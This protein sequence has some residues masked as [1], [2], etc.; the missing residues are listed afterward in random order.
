[1]ET[2]WLDR[3]LVGVDFPVRQ[4][5]VSA[6]LRFIRTGSIATHHIYRPTV[7]ALHSVVWPSRQWWPVKNRNP[8]VCRYRRAKAIVP[9][10]SRQPASD[11]SCEQT[12]SAVHAVR[13][14]S[15]QA[16]HL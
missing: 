2:N 16:I 10:Q 12:Q 7:K 5:T 4:S 13:S 3:R 14:D 9:L 8:I 6:T 11:S 15:S 1:M